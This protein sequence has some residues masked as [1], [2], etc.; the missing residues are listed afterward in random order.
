MAAVC[1]EIQA[2]RGLP[3]LGR[4]SGVGEVVVMA[5]TAGD[6]R[7]CR[8]Q[9]PVSSHEPAQG[10]IPSIAQVHVEHDETR[11]RSSEQADVPIGPPGPPRPN[12]RRVS[13]GL[14]GPLREARALAR[15]SAV[16][17]AA[18]AATVSHPVQRVD[19]PPSSSECQ[20]AHEKR[21]G[22][23][24]HAAH[25][26]SWR[27]LMRNWAGVIMPPYSGGASNRG[28][29]REEGFAPRNHPGPVGPTGQRAALRPGPL[30]S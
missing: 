7:R 14:L 8:W 3:A 25:P 29:F 5:A 24:L 15:C 23:G 18:A 30:R 20:G 1:L 11:G 22:G 17:L 27:A 2:R 6:D 16:G 4:R 9:I 10:L 13:R 26:R 28:R 21:V 12:R 19:S